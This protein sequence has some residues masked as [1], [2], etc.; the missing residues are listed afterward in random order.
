MVNWGYLRNI[1]FILMPKIL[2]K[3]NYKHVLLI[4]LCCLAVIR[5]FLIGN[6]VE[7]LL[8]LV[9]AQILHAATFGSFHFAT[10]QLISQF[11]LIENIKLKRTNYL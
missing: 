8:V 6:Y 9:L 1:N 10:V 2:K 7:I 11:I 5:F 4:S 3:I